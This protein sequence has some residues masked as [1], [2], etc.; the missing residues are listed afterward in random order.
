[1]LSSMSC[2]IARAADFERDNA[3]AYKLTQIL[4]KVCFPKYAFRTIYAGFHEQLF[5]DV[6]VFL[7]LPSVHPFC[8]LAEGNYQGV[9]GED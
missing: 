8:I 2:V 9:H 1:M 5:V 4:V 3:C 7:H 6:S